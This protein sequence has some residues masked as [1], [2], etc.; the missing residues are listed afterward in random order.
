MQESVCVVEGDFSHL[1]LEYSNVEVKIKIQ[2]GEKSEN[3]GK[4]QL[5]P[6]QYRKLRRHIALGE[7]HM[8]KVNSRMDC[9]NLPT[10]LHLNHNLDFFPF[11]KL[12][13]HRI[14]STQKSKFLCVYQIQLEAMT[15][16]PGMNVTVRTQQQQVLFKKSIRFILCYCHTLLL[17]SVCKKL[18]SQLFKKL[19]PPE[20]QQKSL[21]FN[22]N[23]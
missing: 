4:G 19:P 15:C 21:A 16:I 23:S 18:Q 6:L 7:R 8:A 13:K 14:L 11:V 5:L 2:V 9:V 12:S 22:C 3:E 20:F 17:L 1:N 10:Y